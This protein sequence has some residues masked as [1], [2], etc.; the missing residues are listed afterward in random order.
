[1]KFQAKS[2]AL[3]MIFW[4]AVCAVAFGV[5]SLN[6]VLYDRIHI[7][8]APHSTGSGQAGKIAVD[9]DLSDWDRSGEFFSFRLE[10]DKATRNV[11]GCMMYDGE[12][13][14]IGAHIADA[15][16]MMNQMNP[17]AEAWVAW[18]GDCL[19][20]RLSSDAKLGYPVKGFI[21][22]SE[23]NSDSD[24]IVHL[25]IWHYT[26]K[27]QPCLDLRYGMDYHGART[28]PEGFEG[29][30][31]KDADGQGYTLEYAISWKLLNCEQNPPKGGDELA[32]IWQILWS[33]A[34]GREA[35][36]DLSEIRNPASAGFGFQDPGSWGKAIYEKAGHLP[37]GTVVPRQI[38]DEKKSETGFFPITYNVP[39]KDKTKVSMQIYDTAGNTV[40]WLLGEAQRQGGRNTEL[41][42]GLDNDGNSVPPGQYTVKWCYQRNVRAELLTVANNAGNPPYNTSDNTGSWAGDYGTPVA[43]TANKTHV[44]IAHYAGEASRILIKVTPQG[45]RLW[46]TDTSSDLGVGVIAMCNDGEYLYV[47]QGNATAYGNKPGFVKISCETGFNEP[48]GDTKRSSVLVF[49]PEGTVTNAVSGIAVMGNTVFVSAAN[50]EQIRCIDK[51]TGKQTHVIAQINQ[52]RGLAGGPDN[53]LYVIAGV[54][55][56]SMKPDG[57]DRKTLARVSMFGEDP[58]PQQIA[59]ASNGEFFV[60]AQGLFQQVLH[61]APDGKLLNEIGR[62][63]GMSVP[64]PWV[65][66]AMRKPLGLCVAPDGAIWVAE[67]VANPK[68]TSVWTAAGRFLNEF[69]GPLEYSG[70]SVIDPDDPQ[71]VYSSNTKFEMDFQTHRAHPVAVVYDPPPD[72]KSVFHADQPGSSYEPQFIGFAGGGFGLYRFIHYQGRTFVHLSQTCLNGSELSELR[73]GVLHGLVNVCKSFAVLATDW[74]QNDRIDPPEIQK[75]SIHHNGENAWWD[76]EL[77]LYLVSDSDVWK[78]PLEGFDPNGV[79]IYHASHARLLLTKTKDWIKDNPGATWLPWEGAIERIMVD[80][81]TNLYLLWNGGVDRIQRGQGFLDKGHRLAKFSPQGKLLWEYRNICVSFPASWKTL[82]SKPGEIHGAIKMSEFGRY[83][84]LTGYCGQYIILDKE[85]GLYITSFTPD[86]RSDP[87]LDEFAI[88]AENFNGNACY[89]PQLKK[90]LF[91]GGDAQARVW[92]IHGLDDVKLDSFEIKVSNKDHKQ[93]KA[94]ARVAYGVAK[95]DKLYPAKPAKSNLVVDGNLDDWEGAEWVAFGVDESRQTRAALSWSGGNNS[96][97]NVAFDVTDSSPM[98]NRGG[99]NNLLFKTGDCVEFCISS[100]AADVERKDEKPIVGDKRILISMVQ[101]PSTSSGQVTP[102]VMVYEPKSALSEKTPGTF[103]S[104]TG[105]EDYEHVAPLQKAQVVVKRRDGGYAVEA[106]FDAAELGFAP[107]EVGRKLRGDF[108]ALFSDKGGTLVLTRAMWAD[109]SPELGVNNDIPTESRL[110]P[111]RWGWF[112]LR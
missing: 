103:T 112:L 44:F 37:P 89:S 110:H 15:T 46:G 88:C 24:H 73:N 108:G 95:T 96:L 21:H 92:E 6:N 61:F 13:L 38:A 56:L 58:H 2:L 87:P 12:R 49:P 17:E 100:A 107:L 97:I 23:K 50:A 40:R 99:N 10:T 93:A 66:E 69:I 54:E 62:C 90:Y 11:R 39:G 14:Y 30:Y 9:G 53:R 45:Q 3:A 1:M 36:H 77:T 94:A 109:D 7:V 106:R 111:N 57:N 74:N 105:R 85:T 16:P 22:T 104:P 28:N 101:A 70:G 55:I 52:P 91:C 51:R 75:H 42:D 41:W 60:S 98:L 8:P 76:D 35:Q 32:C 43:V 81:E 84:T 59:V 27:A 18:Q 5:A 79:P 80:A 47:L 33:D 64:G 78:I 34:R 25:T 4:C 48:I 20:V 65:K 68:R 63:G 82:P 29:A 72:R 31:K 67:G 102:V 71:C 19:Q 83:L 86:M 26:P